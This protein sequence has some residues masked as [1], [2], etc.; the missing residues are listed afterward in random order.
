MNTFTIDLWLPS[1]PNNEANKDVL[2]AIR[3]ANKSGGDIKI[4]FRDE[5]YSQDKEIVQGE[6]A[7][8]AIAYHEGFCDVYFKNGFNYSVVA[9][10]GG[11]LPDL[12]FFRW[13]FS[14]RTTAFLIGQYV[15]TEILKE[16]RN[17]A[18][19][20]KVLLV[21]AHPFLSSIF[22]SELKRG[23]GD[24]QG[25]DIQEINALD[26]V[27]NVIDSANR[28][29]RY[30]NVVENAIEFDG[31]IFVVVY[32]YNDAYDAVINMLLKKARRR[33]NVQIITESN[34]TEYFEKNK[35]TDLRRDD[36]DGGNFLCITSK[37]DYSLDV[38]SLF[39]KEAVGLCYDAVKSIVQLGI[40]DISKQREHF[41][42]FLVS[43]RF[44]PT[45]R[46][47][48]ISF[49]ED[50]EMFLPLYLY[51]ERLRR[52][53]NLQIQEGLFYSHEVN[54]TE[55]LLA[56]LSQVSKVLD[57]LKFKNSLRLFAQDDALHAFAEALKKIG[58][59]IAN[60]TALPFFDMAFFVS[61]G[62]RFANFS[63]LKWSRKF[64]NLAEL[65]WDGKNV[66]VGVIA[67]QRNDDAFVLAM[68]RKFG[69]NDVPVVQINL[70]CEY[71]DLEDNGTVRI[72]LESC[73]SGLVL[74][75]KW[76][77]M[78][79]GNGINIAEEAAVLSE[80][81]EDVVSLILAPSF[82]IAS[83]A[84]DCTA[85]MGGCPS[86]MF[87]LKK[88]EDKSG[89][90]RFIA[91]WFSVSTSRKFLYCVTWQ[92]D[93]KG[94]AA[95]GGV[96]FYSGSKLTLREL[97]IL[98]NIVSD[99]FAYV[100]GV[101]R[102][103]EL[104]IS[105]TRSAIGSIMSRNGSHNIGSHVLAALSHNVGTM[106]D[107]R[108]LYQYIQHRM[109]YI[110][111]ATT[112][113]P[114]WTYSTPVVSG[115]M[116]EFLSQRHLLDY[117]ANSEGLRAYRFQ[118]A[119]MDNAARDGQKNTIRISVSKCI[120][121]NE[122]VDYITYPYA[123]DNKYRERLSNDV[124]VAIPGGTIGEHAFF[125]ILEN[126]IRNAAKHGWAV[127]NKQGAARNQNRNEKVE[128]LDIYIEVL[129]D[130]TEYPEDVVVTIWDNISDVFSVP[131]K[132]R[133]RKDRMLGLKKL[134]S[135]IDKNAKVLQKPLDDDKMS[136]QQ[137][138]DYFAGKVVELPNPYRS[139]VEVLNNPIDEEKEE[140]L[141]VWSVLSEILVGRTENDAELGH[142]LWLPMHHRQQLK[143]EEPL[144]DDTGT[145]RREN[146]GLAEMK[147]SAG[148]L[149]RR[150]I[151]DIGGIESGKKEQIITAVAREV[152]G[153][154]HLGYKFK[155]PRPKELLLALEA[156]KYEMINDTLRIE[157]I[158]H[159]IYVKKMAEIQFGEKG[160]KELSYKYVVLPY[161]P[162]E[163]GE[164]Y[165][166]FRVMTR[167]DFK[168]NKTAPG[169]CI[170]PCIGT[171]AY[172]KL[173]DELFVKKVE[174]DTNSKERAY[175]ILNKVYGHW[176]DYLVCERRRI[177]AKGA[178][179]YPPLYIQTVDNIATGSNS[180]SGSAG[181]CLISDLDIWMMVFSEMFHSVTMNYLKS[182]IDRCNVD[183]P[184]PLGEGWF[185]F[186]F[187][188]ASWIPKKASLDFVF[189]NE[190]K[191]TEKIV[192][193]MG[194]DRLIAKQLLEWYDDK[195][196][197]ALSDGLIY[198]NAGVMKS[199]RDF[200][201]Q[202]RIPEDYITCNETVLQEA[203]EDLRNFASSNENENVPENFF[204]Y[205][206]VLKAAFVEA[207]VLLRKYEERIV[208][209]PG[210]FSAPTD[211]TKTVKN[212]LHETISKAIG[213]NV[214][215]NDPGRLVELRAKGKSVDYR[216][217]FQYDNY[218]A[219]EQLY[220]ESLS[221][222]QTY[223]N[224]LFQIKDDSGSTGLVTSLYEAGLMRVLIIDERVADFIR[225]HDGIAEAFAKMNMW[226]VDDKQLLKPNI[227]GTAF[228]KSE[229][230]M[231]SVNGLV[232]FNSKNFV[233]FRDRFRDAWNSEK[234]ARDLH[235][236]L[237]KLYA[238]SETRFDIL[239]IHQ[240][241]IDKWFDGMSL[242][243]KEMEL[244]IEYWRDIVPYVVITTGRGTPANTPKTARILPFSV[245]E[246]TLYKKYPEKLVLVDT[247]MNILPK[248][249]R[250]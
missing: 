60:A 38:F 173:I 121:K 110:A 177:V 236:M 111:T 211:Q 225:K 68:I 203:V 91:K 149:Q 221:G 120:G 124:S 178:N 29:K 87:A 46:L 243:E 115:M 184:L 85:A 235:E 195:L 6:D 18:S 7:I 88:D 204:D 143:L 21:T 222:T 63:E 130:V 167:D 135:W 208:T 156:D 99:V 223:L 15:K 160:L 155:I 219:N 4:N 238:T 146:W 17:G 159:G 226:V 45:K 217:H 139:L 165:L 28:K 158:K 65:K 147:I 166:P 126:V 41:K 153:V 24:I 245:V 117:I 188:L 230:E 171:A 2:N 69:L 183:E 13:G 52:R 150:E 194:E 19:H 212:G 131:D 234:K 73:K 206:S 176:I 134:K 142:R 241:L 10:M 174:Y 20:V 81:R 244:F 22:C 82:S 32:G 109:D 237:H 182:R 180:G 201:I 93:R 229:S 80:I 202:A 12:P 31:Q 49:R 127:R 218:N 246:N 116:K 90:A 39:A 64:A 102:T 43:C 92:E 96:T 108:V 78:L 175:A 101:S 154:Y 247:I 55:I 118:D 228:A 47:G 148:Y 44:Y 59:A 48:A 239:I 1:A 34:Y 181:R 170:V 27:Y 119:N 16:T 14:A 51:D 233:A 40:T 209:L 42:E 132:E 248:G 138:K 125:T 242:S 163:N 76:V 83:K 25:D 151:G 50:G 86:G 214:I 192:R 168:G 172:E 200:A 23:Y 190:Q 70:D 197:K 98:V 58:A 62:E 137:L 37:L 162:I 100:Y 61:G 77:D 5:E 213:L 250:K 35:Y 198:D 232:T 36:L 141:K 72:Y 26:P 79:K 128:N 205:F 56:Q 9:M 152:K 71:E 74:L 54:A 179:N 169:G 113:F 224:S 66:S 136:V 140:G 84:H 231:N 186:L 215:I 216:R 3:T 161:F 30:V 122:V 105:N 187:F 123:D 67:C 75:S 185:Q 189:D 112:D 95:S 33:S 207:D 103:H 106:P 8:A 240:G 89:F 104:K 199:V 191:P 145:L 107:D 129:D 114:S 164:P 249:D 57:A 94:E 196:C 157:L 193:I 210:M 133:N 97:Q 144:I 227:D 11:D 220:A 53:E